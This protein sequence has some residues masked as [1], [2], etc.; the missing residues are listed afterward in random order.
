VRQAAHRPSLTIEASFR[1][2]GIDVEQHLDD[3]VSIEVLLAGAVHHSVA[4][5]AYS[6]DVRQARNA[7]ID[8]FDTTDRN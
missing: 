1:G 3:D 4:A 8:R 5:G 2:V 6:F 7:Q